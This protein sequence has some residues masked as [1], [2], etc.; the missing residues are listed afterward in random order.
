MNESEIRNVSDTALWVA[1]YRA[2]ESG[3]PD[4]LFRDP[5][6]RKLAGERG[7]QIF[8]SIPA[9]HRHNWAYSMRTHLA[10]TFLTQ[11][12]DRG[13]DMVIN[14]AAG[15]D[16]R[17]YRMTL[18]ATLQWIEI[19]L[20]DLI[21]YKEK[22]LGDAKPACRLER[23]SVDLADASG[24][25]DLFTRLGKRAKRV[26]I[27]SEGLVIYLSADEVASLATDLAAQPS[28]QRWITDLASPGL[29][30]MIEKQVGKRLQAAQAPL[31]FAP[32]EGPPFFEKYGWRVLEV[33]SMLRT[34]ARLRRVGFFFRLM[35]KLPESKGAQGS[36]PW[37]AMVLLGK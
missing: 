35:S 22:I 29:K 3:R 7:E 24:R 1:M 5:Y 6:A 31:K 34:A 27:V 25:R 23:F 8:A 15:L 32:P 30:Q 9:K 14:L 11:E 33:E 20:P 16:A 4:A 13:A 26:V 12:I 37:S 2:L 10:D 21:A 17:P 36:R 28:F 19:D 18:P